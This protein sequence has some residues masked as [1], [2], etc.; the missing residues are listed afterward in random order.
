MGERQTVIGPWLQ[1]LLAPLTAAG[2]RTATPAEIAKSARSAELNE[3]A[4]LEAEESRAPFHI[5]M[6]LAHVCYESFTGF[7]LMPA[8]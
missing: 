2:R 6:K 1:G 3:L 5:F 4:T 7:L 8:L